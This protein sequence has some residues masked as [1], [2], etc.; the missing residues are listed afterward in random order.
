[1]TLRLRVRPGGRTKHRLNRSAR[2]VAAH[3]LSGTDKGYDLMG[4]LVEDAIAADLRKL[5][6]D[7]T[8]W[9]GW[10]FR[11]TT[12]WPTRSPTSL[13]HGRRSRGPMG[14]SQERNLTR[15]GEELES[16]VRTSFHSGEDRSE[17]SDIEI[18]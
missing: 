6:P 1:V 7:V 9:R 3:W 15:A 5:C 13:G 2:H 10:A 17:S 4:P 14:G 16:M 11:S 18:A 12:G 8:G